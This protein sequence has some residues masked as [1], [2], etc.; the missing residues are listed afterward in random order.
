MILLRLDDVRVGYEGRPVVAG[1]DLTVA[2]GEVVALLGANGAGKTTTLLTVSGLLPSLGG[3]IDV[4]GRG[5]PSTRRPHLLAR[6]GLAHVAEERAVFTDL[7]VAENL[8]LGGRGRAVDEVGRWFP[9][10]L[11]LMGRR[12]GLLSGGEQQ[13]L[14]LG[15]A[16]L[17]S[18]RLLLVD[19]VSLGLAPIV[20]AGILPVLRRAADDEGIGVLLVEQHVPLALEVAHRG[21]VLGGGGVTAT[22]TA[23]ELAEL[24]EVLE[25]SYLGG[26]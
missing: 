4:L 26:S 7:S 10:L 23:A 19:E 2:E 3:S 24:P 13:M 1:L 8:R 14:S 11:P 16:L 12:A 15:R 17:G 6:C 25:A 20:V 5:A 21:Y 22:G 18:P 9:D